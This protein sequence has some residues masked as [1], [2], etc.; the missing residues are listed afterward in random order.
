MSE[1]R[2]AAEAARDAAQHVATLTTD[3]KNDY[4]RDLASALVAAEGDILR[5]NA[6]DIAQAEGDG[7]STPKLKRL[8]ITADSLAQMAEGLRQVA[9]LDDPVARVTKD[10]T[11]D[12]GLRVTRVRCPL[13]VVMM[14]YESRPNVTID[15][16]SLCFKS[17]NACILK[18]GKEAQDSNEALA[19]VIHAT[20][21]HHGLP[22]EALVLVGSAGREAVAE[23]LTFDDCIDLVI[24]RGGETLIRYVSQNSS[25][26]TVQHFHGIC[27]VYVDAEADIDRALKISIT[28]KTS[29]PATCNATEAILVHESLAAK[30][31]PDLVARYVGE[32]VEVRGD[33]SVRAIVPDVTPATA[34]DWG[35]EFLDMIVAVKVVPDMDAA[36]DHIRRFGSDHTDTIVT[37]NAETATE[38][39]QRVQSSCV[40][41]NASTRF[42]DGFQLGMG[43]EIGISTSRVHAYGPMGL[44]ELT[45]QRFVVEGAG[46]IR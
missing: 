12:N 34:S 37:E 44:E 30:F 5:A 45:S 21:R 27:H 14:I 38:F 32:G 31:L 2:R 1:V 16:F 17:G 10:Q 3:K 28:G 25:I 7:L 46:H 8:G 13:G 41:V 29:A 18:G 19:E 23:L 26:P 6:K 9:D 24:P 11:L 36:I 43:A 33:E 35:T 4:L 15:A 40:L 22:E 39:T 42:N 20:L